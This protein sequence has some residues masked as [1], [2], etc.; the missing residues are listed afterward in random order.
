MQRRSLLAGVAVAVAGCA[1]LVTAPDAADAEAA[2]RE[3]INDERASAGAGHVESSEQL[4]EAAREHSADMI[5]RDFY[6]HTNPDGQEPWDRVGCEAGEIIHS[7]EIGTIENVDGEETWSTTQASE[8]AGYA[9][10]GWRNSRTHR[11]VM[12]DPAWASVGVGVAIVD[13]EFMITAKFC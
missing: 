11:D 13:G 4:H 2:I 6:D 7:G 3:A 12:L 10:E 9:L 1:D 8:I 5:E